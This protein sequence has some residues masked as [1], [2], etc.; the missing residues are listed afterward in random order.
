MFVGPIFSRE[1]LTV[2][3]QFRHYLLRSGYVGLL[4][5]LMYTTRQVTLGFQDVQNLGDT[6]RLGSM[7]FQVL[8]VTQLLLVM[9]FALLFSASNVAQEKDRKTLL[10]LLLTD[11]YD[12]EL[13]LG[14]LGAGLLI[15]TVLIGISIPV[16]CLSYILGGVTLEQIF[17]AEV[18][19]VATAVSAGA[20]GSFVA[21]WRDKTFQTLAIGVLG[22]VLYLAAV[23]AAL[24]LL[25][26]GDLSALVGQANPFRALLGI[27]SPLA[28]PSNTAS[29]SVSALGTV[30]ILLA[31]A[32][33]LV[34][35]SIARLRIWYPARVQV[36]QREES[37]AAATRAPRQVWDN[38]IIWREMQTRA[39][40]RKVIFIKLAYV[41]LSAAIAAAL[42]MSE[43]ADVTGAAVSPVTVAFLGLS[44]MS[45]ML[46]N[47]QAVTALTTERDGKTLELLL[48]TDITAREFIFGKLGGVLWN[49]RELIV[50]PLLLLAFAAWRGAMPGFTAEHAVY[51]AVGFSVLV[52]FS[53]V[54]GMH[55]GLT[56]DSS[57]A[58]IGNSLGTMFFLFIG[59]S[60]FMVLLV[61]ARSSFALQFQSF[62][63]FI[64]MGSLGLYASLTHKN[65]SPALTIA[66]GTL[67]FL[68]FYA[69][70]EFLLDGSLGVC[71]WI[72]VAYG[73]AAIAMLIPA[74]S[75]FDVALGRTT[76][77]HG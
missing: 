71:I 72:T 3:R 63:V 59:I 41:V 18:V 55:S 16:F 42:A 66:A 7:I 61:E 75:D 68:T 21:F 74:V 28:D 1:A 54:L 4:F 29:A 26:N 33:V 50:I 36:R 70:T 62:I 46:V 69:I 23:E 52:L 49:T 19:C 11:L 5:V 30:A 12:R 34:S 48:V 35:T 73:F 64:G 39:Y 10:L 58:A 53:A 25:P 65:P 40:G 37:E 44:L 56:F 15:V 45:F 51:V 67:P 27:L 31:I 6:A 57:R 20:W 14:K 13:V 76:I 38:P 22:A 43:P 32:A 24:V 8:A 47:A 2:P 9:F 77:K 17:W 60:I